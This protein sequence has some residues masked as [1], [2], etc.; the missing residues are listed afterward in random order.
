MK[1]SLASIATLLSAVSAAAVPAVSA[2]PALPKAFT[3]V[4]EGGYT[5][6][7]NGENIYF[8][9]NGTDKEILILHSGPNGA[10]SYTQ[11]NAVPTAFQNLF[12]VEKEVSPLGLTRPHSGALPEGGNMTAFGV[13]ERGFL[14][15][16]GNDWFAVEG[17]GDNPVKEVYWYGRHSSTYKAAPLW[18]KECRGC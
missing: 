13:N 5:L 3:L 18:V 7:T 4:A 8:G 16:G 6:L 9:G 10:L 11:Q 17:Y 15:Q 14:T 12:I 2:A 1:L